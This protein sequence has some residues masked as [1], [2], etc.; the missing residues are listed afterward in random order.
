MA[1]HPNPIGGTPF[2]NRLSSGSVT[3]RM[4]IGALL[5]AA[6]LTGSS[7]LAASSHESVSGIAEPHALSP[8]PLPATGTIACG[9]T[10]TGTITAAGQRDSY[11][12]S[13]VA[14]DT[15]IVS[16]HNSGPSL[17][18]VAEI[19]DPADTILATRPQKDRTDVVSLPS[20]GIFKIVMRIIGFNLYGQS[21]FEPLAP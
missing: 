7:G 6:L 13:A 4:V 19:H 10:I 20:S 21:R 12:F 1:G 2:L 14:G 3:A 18:A 16:V 15:V 17:Q 11:T 8:V 9:Q 5:A